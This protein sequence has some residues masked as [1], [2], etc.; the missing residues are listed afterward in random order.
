M[1]SGDP[2]PEIIGGGACMT[3]PRAQTSAV[4]LPAPWAC[5][6]RHTTL[7][8]SLAARLSC[9]SHSFLCLECPSHRLCLES[10]LILQGPAQVPF[11]LGQLLDHPRE[12]L[13][14]S[15]PL[16]CLV[17]PIILDLSH[18]VRIL[19]L[20]SCPSSGLCGQNLGI[21][22]FCSQ[23]FQ[24]SGGWLIAGQMVVGRMKSLGES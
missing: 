11:L 8:F 3:T 4:A 10:L 21:A 20:R 22:P 14:C 5:W 7:P 18:S 2:E 12:N 1:H 15:L 23:D 19:C 16:G 13:L 24:P 17:S 6:P 9:G